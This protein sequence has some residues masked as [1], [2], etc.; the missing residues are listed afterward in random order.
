MY[1]HTCLHKDLLPVASVRY[2]FRVE[3]G[4]RNAGPEFARIA[5][6]PSI[7]RDGTSVLCLL[8]ISI[9]VQANLFVQ[10]HGHFLFGFYAVTDHQVEVVLAG[11]ND[12]CGQMFRLSQYIIE[13][14]SHSGL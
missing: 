14:S 6:L 3:K 13:E 1:S 4:A 5:A 8:K 7:L 10:A 12:G 9:W 11:V 2:M